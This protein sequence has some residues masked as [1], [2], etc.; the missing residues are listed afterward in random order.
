MG[1]AFRKY[2]GVTRREMYRRFITKLNETIAF[3]NQM[4]D[5]HTLGTGLKQR[6]K[7]IGNTTEP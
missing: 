2:D 1:I 5:H 6:R 3:G 7:G 4:E